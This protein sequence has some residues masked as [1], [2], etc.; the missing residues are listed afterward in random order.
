MGGLARILSESGHQVSGSD[1]N[2]YPPM[3]DQLKELNIE[4]IK[5]FELSSMPDADLYVIGNVLSRGNECVEEI[6]NKNLS[7]K[8][9]PEM[10][11]EIIKDRFVIAV[12]G[13]HGKT[14][15]SFM[16]AKIL[17]SVGKDIGYLIG[18]ISPDFPFSAKI[19]T[20]EIFVIEADEYDS[21]FFDK[22]SKFVHYF[23]NILLINNIEF[24]HADI[25]ND[26][27]DIK[28]QFHHLLRIIPSNGKI[29]YFN[30]DKNVSDVIAKGCKAEI[31]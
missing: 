11:G 7:Y 17:E 25:F 31:I 9:G 16:I 13:T 15:T 23:P 12:S 29:I 30:H 28:R 27:S 19:G 8:S 20:D 6:L 14:T 26:L 5:G 18:G 1:K 22:R 10:L 2:F 21:A 24:D 3:S 4:L